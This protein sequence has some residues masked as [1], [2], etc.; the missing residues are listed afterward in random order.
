MAKAAAKTALGPTALI[1]AEQFYPEGQMVITDNFAYR[2]LPASSRFFVN[3]LRF[4]RFRNWIIGLSEKKQPGIWGGLLCRKRYID[5]KLT[6]SVNDIETIVNLGAGFDTRYFRLR[7]R[8]GIPVWEVDQPGNIKAK[9]SRLREIFGKIPSNVRLVPVDFDIEDLSAVL[10]SKGYSLSKRTFLIMEA[11][12]QYLTADGVK[13][14]FDFLS[15]AESGSRLIF[16]YVRKDFLDGKNFYGWESGYKRF[17][18]SKIWHYGIDPGELPGFLKNYGWG[19]TED[20]GYNELAEE[21]L[22]PAG[23]NLTSTQVE[24]IV[25]AEKL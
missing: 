17:V 5:E 24:R 20:R 7:L 18:S 23:R 2:M 19:V 15:K 6:A 10:E 25:Y 9:E 22:K 12:T 16:T 14:N 13:K 8:S 21:Y 11:V 4:D 3:L 1:A